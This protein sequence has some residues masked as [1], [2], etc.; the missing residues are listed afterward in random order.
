MSC[1]NDVKEEETQTKQDN[2][3]I[4]L[5]TIHCP[6]CNVLE[7]KLSAAGIKF[8]ISEDIEEMYKR[9]YKTAPMLDVNGTSYDFGQAIKWLKTVEA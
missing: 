3:K 1:L 2:K 6:K 9:G 7:K 5:Y 4:V 8:Q